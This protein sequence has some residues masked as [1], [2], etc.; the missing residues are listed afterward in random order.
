MVV[1]SG[2]L[3]HSFGPGSINLEQVWV[4]MGMHGLGNTL[5]L[6]VGIVVS[7]NDLSISELR[8]VDCASI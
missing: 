7:T 8:M 6:K 5:C 4:D 1:R 2:C 3:F